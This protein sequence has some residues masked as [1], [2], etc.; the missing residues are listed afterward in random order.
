MLTPS[1]VHE[2][3]EGLDKEFIFGSKNIR[4]LLEAG[5]Q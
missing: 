1:P 3:P 4:K 5:E 2:S